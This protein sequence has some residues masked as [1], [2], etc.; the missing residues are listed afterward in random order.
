[1]VKIW[2]RNIN[3]DDINEVGSLNFGSDDWQNAYSE[4][5]NRGY[6]FQIGF[7]VGSPPRD[8]K[9]YNGFIW[10]KRDYHSHI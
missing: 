2:V 8:Y 10:S 7:P 1:M 9:K 4:M 6:K 3:T 5:I